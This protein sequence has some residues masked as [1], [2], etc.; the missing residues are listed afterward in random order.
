MTAGRPP[1]RFV[2]GCARWS[3]RLRAVAA[4]LL[5]V[6]AVGGAAALA[7]VIVV[8]AVAAPVG[9]AVV[10]VGGLV[11]VARR[12]GGLV[13]LA[14]AAWHAADVW[15]H[16]GAPAGLAPRLRAL[17]PPPGPPAAG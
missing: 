1:D 16:R 6:A 9:V 5:A 7:G 17:P 14:G 12:Q 13:A 3:R 10:V 2:A 4:L 8:L 11:V 15:E